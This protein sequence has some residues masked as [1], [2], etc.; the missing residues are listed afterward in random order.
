MAIREILV[1]GRARYH[2]LLAAAT[3]EAVQVGLLGGHG[4]D[5]RGGGAAGRWLVSCLPDEEG[6]GCAY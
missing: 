4:G 2:E 3:A 6:R 5:T 1:N